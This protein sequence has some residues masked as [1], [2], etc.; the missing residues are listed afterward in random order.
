MEVKECKKCKNEL[1][2]SEFYE[3]KQ[4]G[5]VNGQVWPYLDCFCKTCRLNYGH[6]RR[7]A[8]KQ[9]AVEYLGGKC[10]D[11]GLVDIPEVYDFHHTDPSKKDFTI[12]KS[13]KAFD[14]IK[15]ELDKCILLCAV[16]HRKRHALDN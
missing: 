5:L 16:C 6:E 2:V 3:Q 9:Q 1:P 13:S 12:G 7:R 10:V 15:S 4:V 8:R 11:C 14:A